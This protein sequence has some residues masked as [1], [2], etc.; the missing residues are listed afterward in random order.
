MDKTLDDLLQALDRADK[1][2]NLS[3]VD[4]VCHRCWGELAKAIAAVRHAESPQVRP[5]EIPFD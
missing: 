3:A 2:R 5:M 4:A 1:C